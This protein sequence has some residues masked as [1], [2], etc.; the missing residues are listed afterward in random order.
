[1]PRWPRLKQAFDMHAVD[2]YGLSEINGPG[3]S[4]GESL[5]EDHGR[6]GLAHLGGHSIPKCDN[7]PETAPARK[8]RRRKRRLVLQSLHA[9]RPVSDHPATDARGPRH[10]P[11][12]PAPRAGNAPDGKVTGRSD[13]HDHLPA[14]R[15]C[16]SPHAIRGSPDWQTPPTRPA[17]SKIG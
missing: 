17:I 7:L 16:V 9:K 1:M 13:D 10:P 12:W 14:R 8:P 11:C 6:D 2:I 5:F 15:Q 3:R 4:L